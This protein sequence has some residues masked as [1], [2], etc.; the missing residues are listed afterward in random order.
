MVAAD[1][2]VEKERRSKR[3]RSKQ[4]G[5]SETRRRRGG[6]LCHCL[7]SPS[8]SA[9]LKFPMSLSCLVV[10]AGMRR[11][12]EREMRHTRKKGSSMSSLLR[13]VMPL[14]AASRRRLVV[15]S[16]TALLSS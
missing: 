15:V 11:G 14:V 7:V 9:A 5:E 16:V 3:R 2:V 4:R 13:T 10:V 8:F 12:R 1:A 6:G